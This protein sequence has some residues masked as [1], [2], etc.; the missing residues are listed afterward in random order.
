[1]IDFHRLTLE[2]KDTYNSI[3][4]TATTRGCEYSFAN[5]YLWGQQRVAFRHGCVLFFSHFDGRSVYPYP[6]GSGDRRLCLEEIMADAH[7]RGIPCR[8]VSMTDPDVAELEAWFPG[9]FHLRSDRDS[10]DYV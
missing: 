5:M 10:F 6:I 9:K 7:E 2:Q 3:L 8:I 4:H 1:M